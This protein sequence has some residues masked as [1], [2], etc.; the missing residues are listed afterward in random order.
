MAAGALGETLDF[1]ELLGSDFWEYKRHFS[2]FLDQNPTLFQPV[3]GMD[4][5]VRGFAERVG[6]LVRYGC[7]VEQVRR[8]GEGVRI[9]YRGRDGAE[10]TVPADF[11]SC[12]IP[13]PVPK[14][15]PNDFS[16]ETRAA[17]DSLD[18]VDAV[19]VAFQAKRRFWEEDVAIYG[20]LFWTDNDITQ[21]W[22]PCNGYHRPKG[23]SV[24]A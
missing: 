4:A 9:V 24:G 5:I 15:I 12:T 18:F 6:H 8:T 13:A 14:D 23:V 20:G 19:K 17:P 16:P 3:G 2:H 7:V 10:R 11:A 1:G 21:I 22:Y